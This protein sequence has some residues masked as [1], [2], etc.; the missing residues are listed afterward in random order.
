MQ[1][2]VVHLVVSHAMC[3]SHMKISNVYL[4]FFF[5]LKIMVEVIPVH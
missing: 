3:N 5:D 4:Q 1:D 2:L